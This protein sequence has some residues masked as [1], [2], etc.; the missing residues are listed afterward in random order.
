M[1]S[2]DFQLMFTIDKIG[3][4]AAQYPKGWDDEALAAGEKIIKGDYSRSN[5]EVIVDWKSDRR[6][7]LIADNS[8]SEI[9]DALH[10]ATGHAREP[11]SA[12][13]V[14]MGLRGVAV[15][16]ASAIL[17]ATDQEKYTLVD[18]RAV[19]ALGVPDADYYN[20]NFYLAHYFPE[21]KRLASQ[22]KVS[23][24]MLDRALWVWSKSREKKKSAVR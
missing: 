1:A 14:L 12:F 23:L 17:T 9:A 6:K 16:M 24:R 3:Y 5:L 15:P 10:I 11:R 18:W 2:N 4:W 20:L 22:G 13:A 21:C 19:E 7:K 8:D